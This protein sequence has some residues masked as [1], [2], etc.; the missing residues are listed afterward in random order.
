M[1]TPKHVLVSAV[2]LLAPL[3]LAACSPVAARMENPLNG[4]QASLTHGQGL[5][6]LFSDP[7]S[8]KDWVL[9]D[10]KLKAVTGGTRTVN[11]ATGAM[12]TE[13]FAFTGAAP[14]QDE[15]AFAYRV[16]PRTPEPDEEIITVKVRVS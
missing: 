16:D 9:I 11:G 1:P 13:T 6:V 10:P 7:E 4:A 14:G 3:A 12:G 15:L 8:K 5:V 2:A